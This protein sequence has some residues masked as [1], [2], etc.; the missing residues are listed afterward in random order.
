MSLNSS[1]K[2]YFIKI[3]PATIF[4]F[5]KKKTPFNKILNK[6]Y[7]IYANLDLKLLDE[8]K[9]PQIENFSEKSVKILVIH[10][11]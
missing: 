8:K 2:T 11:H 7:K 1:D 3:F 6:Y 9:K 10:S 4:N 5:Y